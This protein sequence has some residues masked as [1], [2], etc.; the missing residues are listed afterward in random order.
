MA[1]KA[2]SEAEGMTKVVLTLRVPTEGK[3]QFDLDLGALLSIRGV[4]V[5]SYRKA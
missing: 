5:D 1:T 2:V 4:V 3:D